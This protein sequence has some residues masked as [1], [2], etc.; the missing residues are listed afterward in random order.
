MVYSPLQPDHIVDI[1]GIASGTV[2]V[3]PYPGED[4]E[5]P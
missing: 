1:T 5:V 4:F 3:C 2:V